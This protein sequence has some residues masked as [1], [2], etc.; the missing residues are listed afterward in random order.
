MEKLNFI[1]WF[2]AD[3]SQIAAFCFILMMTGISVYTALYEDSGWYITGFFGVVLSLF[4]GKSIQ[5]H[6]DY[7][8]GRSR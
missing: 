2:F 6:N 8:K 4:I 7:L 1:K 5:A 3:K